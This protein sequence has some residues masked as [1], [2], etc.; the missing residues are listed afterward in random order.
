MNCPRCGFENPAGLNFCGS[1]GTALGQACPSCGFENPPQFKFCGECG[2]TIGTASTQAPAPAP[3][4]LGP[5]SFASGRYHV[6]RFLGEGAKKRVYLARDERLDRDVAFALIKT[7][8]LDEAGRTRVRREAQAMGRLGDHPHIVTVYDIGEA[9]GELYIVSQYMSGGDLETRLHAAEGR[10]LSIEQ[11]LRIADELRQALEH[12]HTRGVIHRDLK[13]GNVW[14]TEDDT[15]KLGDFGLALSLDRTR[16]TQEG[17]MVGTAAYMAPE[18]ALSGDVSPRSDLYALGAVLYEMVAGRPPFLGD[19]VVAVI[20]QHINTAPVAP[21]WH[22]PETPRPLEA[23]ILRLLAKDP[24]ERPK[25]AAA[26]KMSLDAVVSTRAEAVAPREQAELNPLDRLAGGVF[27]GRDRELAQLREAFDD[28]VSGRGR[29]LMLVGEPGIGKTRTAEEL[30]TYARL[31]GSQVLWGRCYEGE[32]APA[33]WP[34]VQIIRSYVQ[35]REPKTLLSE[36]GPGAADIAEVVSEVRERLPGLPAPPKLEPEEARFRLFDSITTFIK[37]AS[38]PQPLALIVD[39]LH[40]ADKPSLLLLQ[41]L[42]RELESSRLLLL[43][44]YRDVELGRQHPLEQTLAELA[45]SQLSD[46]VLLRGLTKADV[47][48]FV[49]LTA[50]RAPPAELVEAVYRETE[51]NPFFVH[52]VVQLLQSDGRLDRPDDVESWSLEIPQGVRQVIGHRLSALSE[53]CNRVLAIASVIGREFELTVLADVSELSEDGLLELLDEAEDARIIGELPGTSGTYRFS[54]ALLRETLYEEIRTTR[55]VRLHRQVAEALETLYAAKPEPRLA[56]L[57][58][59][60]CEAASGGDVDKAVAYA[61][62]AAERETELLAYE[63]AAN[64]YERA[65]F[66]LEAAD[67]VDESR[68]CE[69]LI[70]LGE[71][72]FNSSAA[73][74][75]RPT[76]RRAIELARKLRS[77]DQF[78]RAALGL[79][80]A[81]IGSFG[82]ADHE[83]VQMFE[84]GLALFGNEDSA[85][86]AQVMAR[87]GSELLWE[88]S[89]K[90][91]ELLCRE[92]IAMA[93]RAGDREALARVLMLGQ[94]VLGRPEDPGSHLA[95]ADEIVTLGEQSGDKRRE[96]D[97]RFHRIVWLSQMGEADA[98][99]HEIEAY[100]RLAEEL[101]QPVYLAL[102]AGMRAGRALWQGELAEARRLAWEARNLRLRIDVQVADQLFGVQLYCLRRQQ[103]R[104]GETVPVLREGL[105]RFPAVPIWR[106]LLACAYAESGRETDARGVFE[107]L[108]EKD[109]AALR[110][111]PDALTDL[112]LLADACA[113]LGD[114]KMAALFYDHLLSYKG[115]YL[116]TGLMG[117]VGSAGRALGL[118]AA[119]M[120]RWDDA[121]RHFEEAIQVDKQMRARGW[122]P[123]TQCDYAR[124]LLDRDSAGDREKALELLGE[125]LDTCQELGLKGWLD[126]CL[127]LKLRVQGVDSGSITTSLD[128][129][130]SSVGDKR[131]DLA[132]HTAPDGTV[133]LMFSDMEGFTEMTERLG[134]LK[135]HDVIRDH[136]AIVREQLAAH[137]GYEVELQ[138]DGFLLAFESARRGLLCAVAIQRAFAAY[139][140]KHPEEPIRVRIGLHTGEALKD[141]DKFFGKTVILAARI[142]AQAQGGEILVSSL[143]KELTQ[144]VGD[145]RFGKT[146]QVDLKGISER[147]RLHTVEWA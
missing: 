101:R 112:G 40:W 61:V 27:V 90:R 121:V 97:G 78:A 44:T 33:Y 142:A 123:R 41:F 147:Q 38:H 108:S 81:R 129:V 57:A 138:G 128:L 5:T 102:A 80:A 15:A 14:L 122:L 89:P 105:Q 1:C 114:Q 59:H 137:S 11:A 87:L 12:A 119:V 35:E 63:E 144:S 117:P 66:A 32:G 16:L 49:E 88:E 21:S 8:G 111:S 70:A 62:R 6:Q 96:C 17:M 46:R 131:P 134:D 54:H 23:L 83:L 133:T 146:R 100:G 116:C 77:P 36:M 20:S 28:A 4:P 73:A 30:A 127:E 47:A 95:I 64:Q 79:S 99:D 9:D 132:P 72:Q 106:C 10:R 76:F 53:E 69:L 3:Q 34:W 93:R 18:Q 39:D 103:G 42:A 120:R 51:G 104:V 50:G 130:A 52:E 124:M 135:A 115:R 19:D 91:R 143:F 136:N 45:R 22:N 86:R 65:L 139:N 29:I 75:F 13:P 26:V 43:G 113:A 118:L 31:R 85:L 98:I 71:A 56:E 145:L 67:P 125:A 58:Y 84:E 48:R 82:V 2:A 140:E 107:K 74:R 110:T 109:F 37:N 92:A 126:M 68:R 7:E 24:A 141:A 60:F 94:V 25:S 55:R